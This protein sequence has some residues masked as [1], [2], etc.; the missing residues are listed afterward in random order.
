[1]SSLRRFLAVAASFTALWSTWSGFA[2]AQEGAVPPH[3]IWHPAGREGNSF[4]AESRYFRKTFSVKEPS[5]LSLEVTADNAFTLYLDGKPVAT[6]A[7]WTELKPFETKL[8]PGS[9]ILAAEAKNEGPGAAGFL[10]SGSI[11]PLGQGVPIHTNTSWKTSDTVPDGKQWTRLAFDD[12]KWVKPVDLGV[13][14]TGPWTGLVTAGKDAAER[15]QVP[16]GLKV[17]TVGT[18]AVTGSVV[19]F[20]F[21]PDG[22]PCVSI[23]RGPIARLFDDDGDGKFDRRQDITPQMENCQGLSF[24]GDALYA[25]GKGPKGTGLHRLT[26]PDEKGVYRDAELIRETRGGMGEHGPHAVMRGPDG[27]LYYNNG[28]HAH[29][30]PPID[31][32]SPVNVAYEGELLPHY[33]DARGHAAGIMAPGGEIYRSDDE[34]KTWKRIVAGFR[35]EYD[36]GFNR[37]GEIFS[38]DSDMEWDIGLPWYR[39][40]R[41]NFCPIG[42]EFGWRNGAAKWPV[43]AA[44]SLPGIFDVG[45]GSPTGVTFYH[46]SQL[47]AKYADNFLI[48]DWSQGQILAIRSKRRGAGYVG[49]AS[50]LVSGQPLNCTDIEAGPDGAVYFT[51]GGRG[52]QGGLFRVSGDQAR[53]IKKAPAAFPLDAIEIDSPLSSY[54]RKKLGEIKAAHASEWEKALADVAKDVHEKHSDFQRIRALDLLSDFGPEPSDEFLAYF[55]QDRKPAVRGRAAALL[56]LRSTDVARKALTEM[57]VDFNPSVVRRACEGLMQQPADKIPVA[58]LIPLL[59]RPDRWL[60]FA[61]RVAIEHAELT[62]SD[63]E[64]LAGLKQPRARIAGMLALVRATKLDEAAQNAF[65]K[66][67]T[68]LLKNGK[69]KPEVRVE[70]LRLIQLTYMLGP[71]KADAPASAAL[72]PVLLNQFKTAVDTP[73]NRELARLLAYL[74]EPAAVAA[75][76]KHQ[77]TVPDHAAQI[78][79]SYCLRAMKQGWTE[80]AKQQAWAWFETA[81]KWDGGFSFLGYL[82]F[83]IQDLLPRY[84]DREKDALLAQGDKYPFPTRV[85]VRSLDVDQ[86]SARMAEVAGLASRLTGKPKSGPEGELRNLIVEKLTKSKKPEAQA[87]LRALTQATTAATAP[88]PKLVAKYTLDQLVKGVAKSAELRKSASPKRGALVLK[89]IRCLDCHKYGSEGQGVGPDLTTLNSRFGPAEILESIVEPSKVI[90]DQYKSTTVATADGK[91]YNGMPVVND[92]K[93]LVLLLSDGSK[94]TIPKADIDEQ[95]DSKISVMPEGLLNTLSLREIAD[96]IALFESAPKV[97]APAVGAAAAK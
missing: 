77:A 3:W 86:D 10:L 66:R 71:K 11:L 61:A 82:D 23:E 88:A 76:L 8:N 70:L 25:V 53:S 6:G 54:S 63:R 29:L 75:I 87:A 57:L 30:K 41:V 62:A 20:T 26:N 19:A 59:G 65:L 69:F 85:L 72:R 24:I 17:E 1:V 38:F 67:Q 44:D 50:V 16:K 48:C 42:A 34:G 60:R 21:G 2:E 45:R 83:M 32:A 12:S 7:E 74:D 27:K 22:R 52:T 68:A 47:P 55:T 28:N 36:F 33:N 14:G 84:S 91:V 13:L 92:A 31:P 46:A 64:R 79:D 9:H 97:A 78:H 73:V 81:S 56:G 43:Y 49:E 37:A 90:S 39:P 80:E 5:R 15:F 93:N 96:L 35:N 40:V 95:K 4:P 58:K 51:T 18:P 94:V 89:A